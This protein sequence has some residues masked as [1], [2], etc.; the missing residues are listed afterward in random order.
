MWSLK[1]VTIMKKKYTVDEIVDGKTVV[2]LDREDESKKLDVP[3]KAIPISLKE[4][5]IVNI[6]F[7]GD[8]IV[9]V[10]VDIEATKAAR[11]EVQKLLG[12]LKNKGSNGLKW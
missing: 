7:Q 6:E 5:D 12:E 2:L 8:K 1:G 3:V 10:E 11:Q 4:G 9:S